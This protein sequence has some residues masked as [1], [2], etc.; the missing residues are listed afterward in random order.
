MPLGG[1]GLSEAVCWYLIRGLVTVA[2]SVWPG[3]RVGAMGQDCFLVGES[4]D[5][6]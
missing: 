2:D 1:W 5:M 3:W 6:R 4:F